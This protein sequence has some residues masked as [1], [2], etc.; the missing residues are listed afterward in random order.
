MDKA[1]DMI[2]AVRAKDLRAVKRLIA[3]DTALAGARNAKGEYAVMVAMYAGA[4]DIAAY[5]IERGATL[6]TFS[7]AAAGNLPALE[8]SLAA[9][10][11]TVNAFA[12]DGWTALHLAAF[13]GQAAAARLLI[14]RGARV[15]AISRNPSANMPLHVAAARGHGT[16]AELLI[17]RGADVKA[18]A[19]GGW[20]PLHLAAGS[21]HEDVAARLIARGA[22]PRAR[23]AQGHTPLEI[24]EATRHMK[25]AAVLRR[26]A[27]R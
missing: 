11:P 9:D 10:P 2:A 21:G 27:G 16:L 8:R 18:P 1:P 6:D 26:D 22:D 12:P 15:E 20:T 17:E 24:A 19:G 13:F 7:A 14:E 4:A 25:V 23:E 5:L 3:E